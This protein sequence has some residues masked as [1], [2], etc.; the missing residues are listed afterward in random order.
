MRLRQRVLSEI[1]SSEKTYLTDLNNVISVYMEVRFPASMSI[2]LEL[3]NSIYDFIHAISIFIFHILQ[4]LT[5]ERSI[6]SLT[7]DIYHSKLPPNLFI[8]SS[9]HTQPS[10]YNRALHPSTASRARCR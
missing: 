6:S 9:V 7:S 2:Y 4:C 3:Y 8:V 1:T 10:F 5:T